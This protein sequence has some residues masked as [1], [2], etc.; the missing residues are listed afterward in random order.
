MRFWESVKLALG[1]EAKGAAPSF[2]KV[3]KITLD[4]GPLKVEWKGVSEIAK[5]EIL[6][7][8]MVH[9][10]FVDKS[11]MHASMDKEQ[12]DYVLTS[13]SDLRT[14]VDSYV[15]KFIGAHSAQDRFLGSCLLLLGSAAKVA[16]RQIQEAQAQESSDREAYSRF[17][18][19]ESDSILRAESM[20]DQILADFR[21]DA[22]PA[23]VLLI[24]LLPTDHLA[25]RRAEPLLTKVKVFLLQRFSELPEPSWE[26]EF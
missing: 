20:L 22:Y 23:V 18:I 5:D 2:L 1:M 15:D 13:L 21:R 8:K 14:T 4:G 17:E 26:I 19:L 11:V 9:E 25:R 24:D 10:L 7:A 6:L 12:V 16:I 3:D